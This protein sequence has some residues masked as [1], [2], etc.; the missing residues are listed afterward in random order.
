MMS[1]VAGAPKGHLGGNDGMYIQRILRGGGGVLFCLP[2]EGTLTWG[3]GA[4]LGVGE[5]RER[6]GVNGCL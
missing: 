1:V 6:V 4:Y 2:F 3:D 5:T